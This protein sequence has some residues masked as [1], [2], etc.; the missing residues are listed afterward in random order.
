MTRT[1]TISALLSGV[2]CLSACGGST[3]PVE[4]QSATTTPGQID[5]RAQLLALRGCVKG[6]EKGKL[7]VFAPTVQLAESQGGGV[8]SQSVAGTGI[9]FIA[10]PSAAAAQVGM[11]DAQNRLIGLQQQM[12]AKYAK[13]A[14]TAFE[15]QGNVLIIAP[16]GPPPP[17]A[18]VLAASC[19]ASSSTAKG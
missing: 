2:F 6:P 17:K 1:V 8:I 9:E 15:A 12:P 4:G 5:V 14:A 16:K 19:I 11:R 18:G 3:A 10:Y 7:A 13:I